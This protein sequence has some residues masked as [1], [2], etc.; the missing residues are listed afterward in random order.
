[1]TC[2]RD[3]IEDSI[4]LLVETEMISKEQKIELLS[5]LKRGDWARG[6]CYH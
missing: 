5:K 2:K 6:G 1:M 3:E 4:N